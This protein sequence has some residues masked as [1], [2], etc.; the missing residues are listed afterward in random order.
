[1]EEYTNY[2][3]KN[4]DL[5]Q[6]YSESYVE[7]FTAAFERNLEQAKTLQDQLYKVAGGVI[8]SQFNLAMRGLDILDNQSSKLENSID[9]FVTSE[10]TQ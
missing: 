10:E 3:Q 1:M 2:F 5:W 8:N 4:V 9:E 7:H 6:R